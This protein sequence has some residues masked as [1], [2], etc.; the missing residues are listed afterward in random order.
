MLEEQS[1]RKKGIKDRLTRVIDPHRYK[2]SAVV[3]PLPEHPGWSLG[4]YLIAHNHL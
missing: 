4:I 1:L 2:D 3:A